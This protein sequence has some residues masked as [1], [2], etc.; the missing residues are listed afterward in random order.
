MS[1]SRA[2]AQCH[3]VAATG[4]GRETRPGMV[5]PNYPA[6]GGTA[7]GA[8]A[9]SCHEIRLDTHSD[10]LGHDGPTGENRERGTH[11]HGA[12]AIS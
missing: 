8:P 7:Q 2:V 6:V 12:Q 3:L 4:R 5:P 1:E 9:V 10:M 11:L